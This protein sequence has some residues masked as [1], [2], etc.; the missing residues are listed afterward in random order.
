MPI[1]ALRAFEAAATLGSFKAA[2]VDLGLTASAISHHIRDLEAAF[3]EPLFERRHRQVILT[4]AGERLA[5][6]LRPAFAR[7]VEAYRAQLREPFK[8]RL[9]AAPLF[10]TD[11]LLPYVERLQAR[12]PRLELQLEMSIQP[13]NLEGHDDLMVLRYGP[14]PTG[15]VVSRRIAASPLIVVGAPGFAEGN[16]LHTVLTTGPLLTLSSQRNA[17]RRVFPDLGGDAL[18]LVFDSFEGIIQAA[19]AGRG[20]ALVPF[21]VASNAIEG[22]Y[23]QRIGHV[24][25][26]SG[27]DYRLMAASR[28]TAASFLAPLADEIQSILKEGSS[29]LR[30]DG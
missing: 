7:I 25:I 1:S 27:W 16:D 30:G 17:W 21:L 28:S 18:Q 20:V 11:Y 19:R 10:A 4:D 12:L 26:Q 14:K 3:G 22:G 9:S 13:L 5:N 15:G 23:L 2:A 29:S 6:A 8:I 24:E